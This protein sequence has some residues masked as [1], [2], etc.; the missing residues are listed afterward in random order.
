MYARRHAIVSRDL[1]LCVHIH[2]RKYDLAGLALCGGQLLEHWRDNFARSAPVGVEV[3]D[4]IGAAG[5]DLA[6]VLGGGNRGD[7]GHGGRLWD[8]IGVW[9]RT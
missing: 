5:G 6:E 2:L 1:P 7:F 8:V 9:D 3:D 4:G